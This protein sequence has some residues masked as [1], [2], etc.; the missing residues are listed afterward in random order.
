MIG[1]DT[2]EKLLQERDL[3]PCET[4]E[5]DQR[6]KVGRVGAPDA[7]PATIL[8]PERGERAPVLRLAGL[9]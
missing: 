7:V 4:T 2:M 1:P 9:R 5:P 8:V 3:S 6:L